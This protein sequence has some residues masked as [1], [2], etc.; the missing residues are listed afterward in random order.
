MSLTTGQHQY[1]LELLSHE[2][3]LEQTHHFAV[4]QAICR[5]ATTAYDQSELDF[6]LNLAQSPAACLYYHSSK[7]GFAYQYGLWLN[8]LEHSI[9]QEMDGLQAVLLNPDPTGSE[10]LLAVIQKENCEIEVR[11]LPQLPFSNQLQTVNCSRWTLQDAHMSM[12]QFLRYA[13]SG[14]A[15]QCDAEPLT[16]CELLQ[17]ARLFPMVKEN[18]QFTCFSAGTAMPLWWQQLQSLPQPQKRPQ[19]Q[20]GWIYQ[21]PANPFAP[22]MNLMKHMKQSF[23]HLQQTRPISFPPFPTLSQPSHVS[24]QM[25]NPFFPFWKQQKKF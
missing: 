4:R 15:C 12:Q 14:A 3:V 19:P 22:E 11:P 8:C 2:Y 18:Y 25:G 16:W 24:P 23:T 17:Q 1:L 5:Y 21:P 6:L 10:K 7:Q 20:R 9:Y 13:K